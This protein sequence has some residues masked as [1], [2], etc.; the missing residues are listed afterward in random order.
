MSESDKDKEIAE[1]RARILKLEQRADPPPRPPEIAKLEGHS[2]STYRLLD[3][4]SI[5]KSVFDD[6]VANVP[7]DV[8]KQLRTD[9]KK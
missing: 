2:P 3:Q 8:I 6:F 7:E 5:P 4:M 9:G 1:L